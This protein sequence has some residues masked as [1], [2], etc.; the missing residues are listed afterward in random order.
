MSE[1]RQ[2]IVSGDWIILAPERAKRPEEF[3]SKKIRKPTP[4]RTCPFE[5]LQA[6]GNWPPI[7][8]EPN[9]EAWKAVLI[10]N[11]Y[12]ALRHELRCAVPIK[13]GPYTTLHGVGYHD[14]VI[15]RD[16]EKQ[17]AHLSPAD[18]LTVFELLERRYQAFVNDPCLLYTSAFFNWGHGAGASLFHPHYQVVTLPI[19]PPNV[20]HSLEDS[21][22]YF[23]EH[24]RCVHCE[25]LKYDR[26][27]KK[28]VIEENKSAI[29][30]APFV[31]RTPFE[32][33][34]FPKRHA[35][36]FERTPREELKDIVAVLQS[37]LRRMGRKLKDPDFNFF[38][39]TS[40]LKR[41]ARYSHYHW[42]IEVIP[43]ISTPAGFELGTGMDMNVIPPEVAAAL[44]RGKKA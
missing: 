20:E 39:H 30:V 44:L 10:P 24:R 7:L 12:P 17:F 5:D 16:H 35:P 6:T 9:D 38:I 19:V 22:R 13:Q 15:T 18:A 37:V 40:P 4:K 26:K 29:V 21:R 32:M 27:T 42:H 1:L 41:Q 33:R 11:K 34:V 8:S 36:Y 14:L 31:S 25:L 2:D 28:R 43:K 3:W 23:A